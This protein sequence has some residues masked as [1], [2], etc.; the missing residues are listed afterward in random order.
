MLHRHKHLVLKLVVVTSL[1]VLLV[2][3]S[4]GHKQHIDLFDCITIH[5]I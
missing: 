5:N 4:Y 1:R 2:A 3:I